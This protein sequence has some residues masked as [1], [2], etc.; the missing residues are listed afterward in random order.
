MM[1]KHP[2][3]QPIASDAT[4]TPIKGTRLRIPLMWSS[5]T[6]FS[7]HLPISFRKLGSIH[8]EYANVIV[9]CDHPLGGIKKVFSAAID[10]CRPMVA[11]GSLGD[12]TLER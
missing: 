8:D 7:R 5:T 10:R 4:I 2:K 11:R 3:S 12:Q 1:R 9:F 6:T